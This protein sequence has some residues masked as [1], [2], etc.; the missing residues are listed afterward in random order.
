MK[1]NRTTNFYVSTSFGFNLDYGLDVQYFC[2]YGY[3]NTNFTSS[4]MIDD[5]KFTCSILLQT[6][7]KVKIGI[8]MK[9]QGIEK[10][11]TNFEIFNVV[12]K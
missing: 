2:H 5:G 1:L 9:S 4:A 7:G 12:S 11:I 10:R 3:N 6:E 8:V